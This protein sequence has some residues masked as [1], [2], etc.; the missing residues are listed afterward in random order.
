V[1]P[2]SDADRAGSSLSVVIPAFNEAEHLA[3][4]IAALLDAVQRGWP[5]AELI[6]VDDGSTDGTPAVAA[7]AVDGRIP[8]EVLTQRNSG[9]LQARRA[10]LAATNGEFVLLLDARVTLLPDA[11]AFVRGRLENGE[12]V[13]N[14]HVHVAA[15]NA[16]GTFWRLLAELAWR[17]YFDDPR[18]TSFGEEDFDRFPKGTTCFLAPRRVLE[19]AFEKFSTRYEDLRLANDDTTILR[20]LARDHRINISPRFACIY[21]SRTD[22]AQFFRHAVHRGIVFLDGHATP[23]SRF[24]PGVVAFF[25]VSAGLLVASRRRPALL[26]LAAIGCGV[27]AATYGVIARRSASEVRAL[28]QVTP[29][30]AVGHAL[31]M[32]EGLGQLVRGRLRK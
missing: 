1:T 22:T 31:G 10:G 25:P 27:A 8:V 17:D 12:T 15:D 30:Y 9:R 4:T 24:F 19:E 3:A 6:V 29:L 18:T 14:G 32:W 5:D 23:Q 13:W 28:L 21:A 2:V 26:P 7:A 20:H 16:L 11:L